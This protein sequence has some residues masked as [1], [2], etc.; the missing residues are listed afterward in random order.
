M[1]LYWTWC[2]MR[3]WGQSEKTSDRELIVFSEPRSEENVRGVSLI[4]YRILCNV[5]LSKRLHPHRNTVVI[6]I[7]NQIYVYFPL[8]RAFTKHWFHWTIVEGHRK[9]KKYNLIKNLHEIKSFA[10]FFLH[11]T[12]VNPSRDCVIIEWIWKLQITRS[13]HQI[14][15]F[16]HHESE[17]Q[18]ARSISTWW[19]NIR[20][21]YMHLLW[22]LESLDAK[23]R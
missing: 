10:A 3:I 14:K 9:L 16:V 7:L 19:F 4:F 20:V 22:F 17:Q 23:F 21:N 12:A 2:H 6:F 5:S 1:L 15:I 13:F 18:L 8:E 11:W